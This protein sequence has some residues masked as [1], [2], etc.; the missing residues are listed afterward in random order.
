MSREPS[1]ELRERI[2]NTIRFLAVDAVEKANSRP[3]GRADGPRAAGLR[4]VGS[5]PAL[6]SAAIRTGRCATASCS[7]TAT[8]RCCSTRCSTCS[9]TTSRSTRSC[10]SASSARRRP[11]HPEY[12]HTPGVEVTTG[13]LGQGFAHGVGMALAGAPRARALRRAAA[14]APDTTIVYGIVERRRPDG[15]RLR[16]GRLARRAPRARQPRSIS[17]TTTAS[18]STAPPSLRSAR[19]CAKRFEAQRWH[20]QAVDGEDT[21]RSRRALDGGARRDRAA[22]RSIITA[23]GDRLRQ[24]EPRR[25]E[26]GARR[27]ARRRGGAATKQALGWPL[28]PEFLVPD[29]VRAYFAERIASEARGAARAPT[30]S[31]RPGARRNPRRR[32][33]WDAARERRLPADL[34][35]QLCARARG[36]GRRDAQARRRRARAARGGGAVL[37]RRLGRSRR[38]DGTA[39]REGPRHRRPRRRRGRGSVRRAQPPL[40]HSRAR[41]GRDHERHRA[42]RHLPALLRDLPDLQRLHAAV[43]PARGADAACRRSS[44]SRTT[45][46]SSARTARRTS[47]SSSSTRCAR[48]R[49]SP[50]C[51]RPTASRRRWPGRWIARHTRAARR[52]SRSR[53]RPLPALEAR[54][55]RSSPSDVLRGAYCVQRSG[56]RAARRAGRH[57]LRGVARLRRRGE[58]ARARASRRAWSRCRASSCFLAQPPRYQRAAVPDDGTPVVAVEAGRGESLRR[59]VGPRGLV[60]GID[61]F[62]ASAPV[63]ALAESLRLHAGRDRG[64]GAPAARRSSGLA[65]TSLACGS[66]R[67]RFARSR[68]RGSR[69]SRSSRG[70]GRSKTGSAPPGQ[71]ARENPVST[72][73]MI[74][75]GAAAVLVVGWLV[76]SFSEPGRRRA[77]IEWLSASAMYLALTML[78]CEPDLARLGERQPLRA[79]RLRV[80]RRDLR[81]GPVRVAL[82]HAAHRARSHRERGRWAPRTERHA[83]DARAASVRTASEAV[84]ASQL[85]R[86]LTEAPVARRH[87]IVLEAACRAHAGRVEGGANEE[88][89]LLR[90][91]AP[92]SGRLDR[93]GGGRVPGD[94][95]AVPLA[96]ARARRGGVRVHRA[97]HA[98]GRCSLSGCLRPEAA[99]RVRRLWAGLRPARRVGRSDPS[100]PLALDRGGRLRCIALVREVAGT[101]AAGF[102]L[103]VFAIASA[104]PQVQG[105]PPTPRTGCC[106]RSCCR[107]APASAAGCAAIAR[108]GS[109]AAASRRSRVGS[110]RSR[111][112]TRAARRGGCLGRRDP[113]PADPERAEACCGGAL[114]PGGRAR[115]G[116]GRALLRGNG[117]LAPF[118]DAVFLHNLEYSRAARR[119]RAS[120]IYLACSRTSCRASGGSG[121]W[122]WRA[123]CFQGTCADPCGMRSQPGGWRPSRAR[124]SASTSARTISCR[125]CPRCRRWRGS[126]RRSWRSDSWRGARP[127]RRGGRCAGGLVALVP[128]AAHRQPAAG[129]LA[130]PRSRAR[131]MA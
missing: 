128:L 81:G 101:L 110:S 69:G 106:C 33:A 49:T 92:H 26:Q 61:R 113:R 126:V 78:F 44:S 48:S 98:R 12:G 46:S 66:L 10:A 112:R 18:R 116:A 94:P 3:P 105:Q 90:C 118:L 91:D 75:W 47:R 25:Q 36:Q 13:P 84:G 130:R 52:C 15:G 2:E 20:V 55:R 27:A 23:H 79:G 56:R 72:I 127:R 64:A 14:R 93:R 71:R 45:R 28:E 80:P 82:Q 121:R 19:T 76:V 22:R 51:A 41:D 120:R 102:A 54:R 122:R 39:D 62:G 68:G 73:G 35:T 129:G 34:A 99:G 123:G 100:L 57:G 124:R 60:C 103:L 9:A 77:V 29:D 83:C 7:R 109:P 58:A 53:A 30:R 86:S 43:D 17:T 131:S 89:D 4:A 95:R 119:P 40:R 5:A 42:R 31:S 125:R 24:P 111:S 117:A 16:R 85:S 104:D 21:R 74:G 63:A 59:F 97:A 1:P 70:A 108:A 6:R 115:V 96:A 32:R 88:A 37:R 107:R 65:C 114:R 50:S 87:A 11:G 38:L 67:A 8:P